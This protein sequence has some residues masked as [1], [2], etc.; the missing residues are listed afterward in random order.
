MVK[1][2]IPSDE[3]ARLKA[4][5]S[6]EVLDTSP[7]KELDDLVFFASRICECPI[8]LISLID[9]QRQWFKAKVGITA[10]ETPRDISFCGH[11]IGQANP[12][13]VP[14]AG[15]DERFADNPLVTG[16]PHIRFYAGIPLVTPEGH[17]IGTLCVI[18]RVPRTLRP[19]QEHALAILSRQ[20]LVRLELRKAVLELDRANQEKQRLLTQLQANY[21]R[22][23]ELEA[24]RDNLTHMIVHDLRSPLTGISGYLQLL[25]ITVGGKL[26]A[27]ESAMVDRALTQTQTLV[28]MITSLLDVSRLE[29]GEMPLQR[30][31]CDLRMVA[32]EGIASLGFVGDEV[33]IAL[34][35]PSEPVMISCDREVMKRVTTNLVGNAAKFTPQE[36]V[37]RV[38]VVKTGSQARV[39]VLDAGPGIAPEY[40]GKIFKKFGQVEV[41]AQQQRSSSGLGLTFCKL[42]VE[43]HGGHI[44]AHNEDGRV[45][46]R[47]ELPLG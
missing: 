46:F 42:A 2:P 10:T 4:L 31:V 14:D 19:D 8:A 35:A 44:E 1:A 34:E 13:V 30:S 18:D 28:E 26:D 6:Y 5:S 45:V 47:V 11:A 22:L 24:L 9:G 27:A 20:V 32:Q 33:R 23:Q 41:R 43:A 37:V 38:T 25:K 16:E 7:E 39:A 3:Q 40:H 12:F 17:G 21:D 36:G 15:T 29:A